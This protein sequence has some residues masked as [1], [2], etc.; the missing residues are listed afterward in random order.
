MLR[1]TLKLA[2][3]HQPPLS[4][5]NTKPHILGLTRTQIQLVIHDNKGKA[6]SGKKARVKGNRKGS[7][8]GLEFR[9]MSWDSGCSSPFDAVP[10]TVSSYLKSLASP[11]PSPPFFPALWGG[12]EHSR[13]REQLR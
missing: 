8:L 1:V 10:S 9:E 2:T 13:V 7:T 6:N 3:G 4:V 5:S 12:K 11:H